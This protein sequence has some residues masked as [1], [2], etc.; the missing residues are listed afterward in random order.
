M[1]NKILINED[2]LLKLYPL[3]MKDR[4]A[5]AL[6]ELKSANLL[7]LKISDSESFRHFIHLLGLRYSDGCTY[8][9]VRNNSYSF[10][11][12]FGNKTDAEIFVKDCKRIWNLDL[13]PHYGT[14]AF[15]VYLPA[16]IARLMILVGSPIG[17]KTT[18][19]F[20]VPR[21]IF[22][23]PDNLKWEF[24]SGIFTG[25]GSAPILQ[26]NLEC[27]RSLKLSLNSEKGIVERFCK[28]FM[29]DLYILLKQLN[30]KS[31]KPD[32]KWK[33]PRIAKNST[34]TY[35]VVLRILTEKRNMIRF[36]KNVRYRYSVNYIKKSEFALSILEGKKQIAQMKEYLAN[37]SQKPPR[38]CV[39]L[40]QSRQRQLIENAADK[41]TEKH[42]TGIYKNL[43]KHLYLKCE[44]VKSY[45]FLCNK[46]LSD[47]KYRKAFIPIDCFVE[48]AKL[49][50]INIS[51]IERDIRE[52]KFIRVHNKFAIPYNGG[53]NDIFRSGINCT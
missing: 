3:K 6:Q 31:S 12:C 14:R 43:A 32:I 21:W 10:Y 20:S 27:S 37:H 15:Y 26:P 8:K 30:I 48:L 35:P 25:D 9:Q 16:S 51:D 46:Y 2:D 17:R 50:N 42:K 39:F 49:C 24:L 22:N 18:K 41:F 34:I 29:G 52:V 4:I 5:K 28:G 53:N 47:W 33:E 44:N 36:L 11:I 7:P 40:G 13:K 1:N 19:L 38:I 23:L 45:H